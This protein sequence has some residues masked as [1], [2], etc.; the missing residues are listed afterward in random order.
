MTKSNL[1]S[2]RFSD[3]VARILDRFEGKSLN[4][5][6][7]NLVRFC[8]FKV[9]EVEKELRQ[10][11]ASIEARKQLLNEVYSKCEDLGKEFHQM[12]LAI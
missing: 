5:K 8:F 7:E 2:F 4:D 1:R 10:I 11:E 6:F 12:W 9:P 3:D